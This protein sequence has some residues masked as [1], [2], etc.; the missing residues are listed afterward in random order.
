MNELHELH[1]KGTL[2]ERGYLKETYD[3]QSDDLK[4]ELT[5]LGKQELRE[6]LKDPANRREFLLMAI[7]EAKKHPASSKQI[8][9]A[10]INKVKEFT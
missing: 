7:E 4:H 10:A 3:N 6:I 8:V 5:D 2:A 9:L 1:V